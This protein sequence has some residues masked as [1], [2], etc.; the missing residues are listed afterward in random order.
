MDQDLAVRL[1]N[2]GVPVRAIARAIQLPSAEIRGQLE[3]ARAL[4]YLIDIPCEDWPAGYPREQRLL[5][6]ARLA[7][8]NKP[9]L[10]TAV[11]GIFKL[12]PKEAEILV[13]LL[14]R[15][16]VE[17]SRLVAATNGETANP[18][19]I[20]MRCN[21]C[22]LRKQIE[23]FGLA[24]ETLYGYGYYMQQEHR[25]RALDIILDTATEMAKATQQEAHYREGTGNKRCRNCSMFRSPGGCT[26]VQ[27]PIRPGGLCDYF[28]RK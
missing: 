22:R 17:R 14:S 8:R 23:P 13:L 19:A 7:S 24:I 27:S 2:E 20:S 26:V 5:Q 21:L 18:S 28:E 11:R 10:E 25:R 15:T 16:E 9:A 6:L 4:G 1:A 12:S 3:S